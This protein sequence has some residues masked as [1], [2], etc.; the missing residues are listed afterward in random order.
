MKMIKI[1]DD[2][3][4]DAALAAANGKATAHTYT[5]STQLQMIADAAERR[6]ES[7]GVPKNGRPDAGVIAT[8]GDVLPRAYK[9]APIRTRITLIR[10]PAGW[11]VTD[12]STGEYYG[13]PSVRLVLTET[14]DAAAVSH[15][16]ETA[17][18]L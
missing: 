9:Y 13:A 7:I 4:I 3:A 15:L 1:T 5:R 12:I 10:R 11:Y 16:R 2:T 6:L 8:S 18:R 17:S 14:Q